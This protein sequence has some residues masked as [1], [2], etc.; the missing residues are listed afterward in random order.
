MVPESERTG[1]TFV[2]EKQAMNGDEM[3]AG[4]PY[5]EQILYQQLRLLYRSYRTG[6]IGREAATREKKD[7]LREYQLNK[8]N[9]DAE[10]TWVD[11]IK[12]TELARAECR[13]NP[14]HESTMHLID[15]LEGRLS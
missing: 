9:Y 7:F 10:Y 6:I 5:P 1:V 4:L 11:I 12:K 14:S 2:W 13:K 8:V 15:A 3:P